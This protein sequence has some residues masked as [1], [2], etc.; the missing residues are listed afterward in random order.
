ML[1]KLF[2]MKNEYIMQ[3]VAKV[4]LNKNFLN[5]T[6]L[7]HFFLEQRISVLSHPQF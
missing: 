6:F 4:N 3:C 2:T 7:K 5:E 1:Q